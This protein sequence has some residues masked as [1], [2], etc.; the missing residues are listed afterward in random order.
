MKKLVAKLGLASKKIDCCMNR[1]MLYT[2][3]TKE[4]KFCG[5]E[6]YKPSKPSDGLKTFA[7][8]KRMHY[9]PL[10][11]RL[12]RLYSSICSVAHMRWHAENKRTEGVMCHPSNGEVW[13][14]F[15]ST[16]PDFAHDPRNVRLGLCAD[17]F[18][19]YNQSGCT[20]SCWPIIVTPYNLPLELYMTALYMFL[21]CI[22]PT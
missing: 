18:T 13:K 8:V 3:D 7:P 22:I 12:K 9:L 10:I 15:D 6:K 20:Y 17:S 14:H 2:D 5:V 16:Y 1:C 4:C 19:P 11:L 21:T